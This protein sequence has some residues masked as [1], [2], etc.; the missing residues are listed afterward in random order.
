MAGGA[1]AARLRRGLRARWNAWV[2]RRIPPAHEVLLSQKNVFIFPSG[3]GF[4][5]LLLL[6]ALLVAGINYENNL[7]FALTFLLGGLFV[8]AILHTYANLAQLRVASGASRPVFAG[9]QAGFPVR[10]RDE[11]KRPHDA[12]ALA[13]PGGTPLGLRVAADGAGDTVLF[14]RA[15]HRGWLRPGRLR[16][17]SRYP[18]GL[19]RAWSWLDLDMRC[20]VY[21]RPAVAGA[22]PLDV[23]RGE[24]GYATA[25]PGAE[26]FSG[27]RNYRAG[28]P[29]R[30]VAWKTLAKGQPLQTR[31]Y[32]AFA[33]RR[34]WLSWAQTEGWGGTEER[35]SLLCRW[36]LELHAQQAEYGLDIPG[37][38]LEPAAGEAQRDRALT[39]LALFGL[40]PEAPQGNP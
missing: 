18:L 26:D 16:I 38:R 1:P 15:A 25:D 12:I 36:V 31:E 7:V 13:W 33:E 32:V 17:E 9:E 14:A 37:A 6:L 28:D 35:L 30:H 10:V 22:L 2:W 3:S 5:F 29:L 24:E 19:L 39:A 20:L 34:L 23:G 11:G 21:P 27:F 4:A 8:V 40:A